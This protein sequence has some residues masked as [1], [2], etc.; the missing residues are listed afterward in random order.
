MK[1]NLYGVRRTAV[2]QVWPHRLV[3]A[4]LKGIRALIQSS[5]SRSFPVDTK[6]TCKGC[7]NHARKDDP[8]H[9]RL[10]GVCKF[11]LDVSIEWSC[12][13]CIAHKHSKDR[14]HTLREGHCQWASA[15]TR[16]S[17]KRSQKS[18]PDGE[19]VEE[20]LHPPNCHLGEWS[21]V[22][23]STSTWLEVV[24]AQPDGMYSAGNSK[25]TV[26]REASATKS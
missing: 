2:A 16:G 26:Q 24:A 18:A 10:P 22:D 13:A 25:Y 1:G 17:A 7:Q 4:I 20:S 12:P 15:P 9:N 3:T 19:T 21:K 23:S 5:Y 6:P 8:R 11:P 14:K